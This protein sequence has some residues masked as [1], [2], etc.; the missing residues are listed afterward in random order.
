VTLDLSCNFIEDK[1]IAQLASS[2]TKLPKGMHHL[3]L[4]HCSLTGKVSNEFFLHFYF[5]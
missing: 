5:N 1:G 2:I 3:N 4:S